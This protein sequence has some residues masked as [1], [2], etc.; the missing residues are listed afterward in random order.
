MGSYNWRAGCLNEPVWHE[1]TLYEL[2]QCHC[3]QSQA[4]MVEQGTCV[5][6]D[7]VGLDTDTK[8]RI[9]MHYAMERGEMCGLYE[10]GRSR[11]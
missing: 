3:V 5:L 6:A 1:C 9:A 7:K 10:L 2:V 11:I 4:S 8:M